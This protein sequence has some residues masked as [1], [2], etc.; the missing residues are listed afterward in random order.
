[1]VDIF[2]TGAFGGCRVS[3]VNFEIMGVIMNTINDQWFRHPYVNMAYKG[4]GKT[5]WKS[6]ME[7]T[8]GGF[9][10]GGIAGP[11]VLPAGMELWKVSA[12]KVGMLNDRL[13]E[14]WCA[15]GSFK[16]QTS[17]LRRS[18]EEAALNGVPFHVYARVASCVKIEWNTMDKLQVIKLKQPVKA[19]WGKFAPMNVHDVKNPKYWTDKNTRRLEDMKR[20]GYDP[21]KGD[22][23]LGGLDAYQLFIPGLLGKHVSFSGSADA[24]DM[25]AIKNLLKIRDLPKGPNDLNWRR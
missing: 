20:R 5:Q 17:D 3:L 8:S 23:V 14:W 15:K 25:Q 4:R 18:V 2:D 24:G 10:K 7:A 1:M 16:Q 22:A 11:F 21:A 12:Y 13:S 19:L 9:N 6:Y